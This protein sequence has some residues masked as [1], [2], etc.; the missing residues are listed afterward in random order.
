MR[1]IFLRLRGPFEAFS[2]RSC[3]L[4][5]PSLTRQAEEGQEVAQ[6]S[7]KGLA[8]NKHVAYSHRSGSMTFVPAA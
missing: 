2:C 5:R 3:R 8:Q 1:S 4:L 7:I 6:G